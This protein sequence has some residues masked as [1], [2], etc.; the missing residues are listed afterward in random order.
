MRLVE[1]IM[2]RNGEEDSKESGV[3]EEAVE[4]KLPRPNTLHVS[5]HHVN[6]D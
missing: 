6:D 4:L 1:M 2:S 3:V 5:K